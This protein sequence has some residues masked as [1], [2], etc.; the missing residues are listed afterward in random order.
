M[1][2]PASVQPTAAHDT[3]PTILRATSGVH[4]LDVPFVDDE[5]LATPWRRESTSAKKLVGPMSKSPTVTLASLIYFDKFPRTENL[6]GEARRRRTPRLARVKAR[7]CPCRWTCLS[8][9]VG[10]PTRKPPWRR[11]CPTT[12]RCQYLGA[13]AP[14]RAVEVM[15][16]TAAHQRT[17]TN[18]CVLTLCHRCQLGHALLLMVYNDLQL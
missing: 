17:R 10:V 11:Y 4:P 14:H 1:R 13:D 5:D 18:R 12:P 6:H 2:V 15:A 7:N 16:G 9:A 3:E 8:L